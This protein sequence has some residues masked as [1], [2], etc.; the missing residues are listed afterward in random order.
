METAKVQLKPTS[1]LAHDHRGPP[2]PPFG[3]GR[4]HKAAHLLGADRRHGSPQ[5]YA[6]VHRWQGSPAQLAPRQRRDR[7]QTLGLCRSHSL[8]WSRLLGGRLPLHQELHKHG[9]GET[10]VPLWTRTT[11]LAAPGGRLHRPGDPRAGPRDAAVTGRTTASVGHRT[12]ASR[13]ETNGRTAPTQAVPWH[14]R[15]HHSGVVVPAMP[16]PRT[17]SRWP[18]WPDDRIR[19]SARERRKSPRATLRSSYPESAGIASRCTVRPAGLLHPRDRGAV[20]AAAARRPVFVQ[21]NSV[22]ECRGRGWSR[23]RSGSRRGAGRAAGCRLLVSTNSGQCL[24]RGSGRRVCP[25]RSYSRGQSAP[26]AVSSLIV[27][28]S[29]RFATACVLAAEA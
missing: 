18:S 14:D 20:P 7:H 9:M 21:T 16:M 23:R 11:R 17:R 5:P 1:T 6:G 12:A 8:R 3:V 15:F 29:A 27:S 25:I 26:T 28:T 24:R 4:R 10:S 22:V 19:I 13:G 2:S